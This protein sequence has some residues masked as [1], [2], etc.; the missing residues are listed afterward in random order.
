MDKIGRNIFYQLVAARVTYVGN[1]LFLESRAFN[2]RSTRPVKLQSLMLD[3][4]L[5]FMRR[6][7]TCDWGES[8]GLQRM[9]G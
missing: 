3:A 6:R 5:K 1:V 9:Q 7:Q 8:C 2:R 4:K